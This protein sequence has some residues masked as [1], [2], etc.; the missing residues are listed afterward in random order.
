MLSAGV[1]KTGIVDLLGVHLRRFVRG[2]ER[3]ALAALWCL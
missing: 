2:D 1:R 3:R